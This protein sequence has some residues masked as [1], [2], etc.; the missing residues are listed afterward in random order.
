MPR[1]YT[2]REVADLARLAPDTIRKKVRKA[3]PDVS[4]R[5]FLVQADQLAAFLAEIGVPTHA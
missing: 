2:L 1:Y 5:N 4:T 3:R